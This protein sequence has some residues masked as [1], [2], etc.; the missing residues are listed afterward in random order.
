MNSNQ[1]STH[2][3]SS[4]TLGAFCIKTDL[5]NRGYYFCPVRLHR[6][7]GLQSD[8]RTLNLSGSL[9]PMA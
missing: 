9:V 4:Q 6:P 8:G 2:E 5:H 3:E 1:P 7:L